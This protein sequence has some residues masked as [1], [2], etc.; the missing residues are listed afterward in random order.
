MPS[1]TPRRRIA[2]LLPAEGKRKLSGSGF[3]IDAQHLL[4]AFHVVGDRRTGRL[5]GGPIAVEFHD[6]EDTGQ[7]FTTTA[8]V[9]DGQHDAAR[10]WA[11]VR[12]EAAVPDCAPVAL[13]RPRAGYGDRWDS[14]GYAGPATELGKA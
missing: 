4:T 14:Y 6:H 1:S 13:R 7:W 2:R 10:D 11:L 3:A 8:T 12:C 9:V 5:Y